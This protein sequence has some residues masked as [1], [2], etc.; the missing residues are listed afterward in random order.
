M[1]SLQCEFETFTKS[2]EDGLRE[3]ITAFQSAIAQSYTDEE[4]LHGL[5][6]A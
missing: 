2:C 6:L 5:V 3:G 4:E 1:H